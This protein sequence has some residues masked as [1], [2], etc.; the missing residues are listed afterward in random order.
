MYVQQ[1]SVIC[2]S[3]SSA[4]GWPSNCMASTVMRICRRAQACLPPRLRDAGDVGVL[5]HA[6]AGLSAVFVAIAVAHVIPL[7]LLARNRTQ[8]HQIRSCIPPDARHSS[9]SA[10]ARQL[11]SSQYGSD[12]AGSPR[13]SWTSPTLNH[14]TSTGLRPLP[15]T[16][17]R[18]RC[19]AK[20]LSLSMP[21]GM[22]MIELVATW[23]ALAP[24]SAFN[25]RGQPRICDR[26]AITP[27]PHDHAA[28][29]SE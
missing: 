13:G 1:R 3:V 25:A 4:R 24:A 21:S 27:A 9:S 29:R 2:P 10:T 17:H 23:D 26:L 28:R 18:S 6:S 11:T 12:P 7:D 5:V 8:P 22:R 20:T 15:V 16:G 14:T 19:L